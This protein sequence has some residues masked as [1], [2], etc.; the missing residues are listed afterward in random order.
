MVALLEKSLD[1][2]GTAAQCNAPAAPV[3][4]A[5]VALVTSSDQQEY[6]TLMR[7]YPGLASLQWRD[8]TSLEKSTLSDWFESAGGLVAFGDKIALNRLWKA[9]N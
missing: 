5:P 3:A 6:K 2:L 9:N 1:I 7:K 8:F 4:P